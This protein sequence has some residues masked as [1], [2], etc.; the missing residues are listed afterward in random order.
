MIDGVEH[1]VYRVR[2]PAY[3]ILRLSTLRRGVHGTTATYR[4]GDFAPTALD[5]ILAL[6]YRDNFEYDDYPTTHT[7]TH[8]ST[9]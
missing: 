4:P 8:R 6:P 7:S 9:P 5:E 1:D 3:S 2:V